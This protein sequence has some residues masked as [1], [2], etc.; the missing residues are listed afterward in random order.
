MH[1]TGVG[2]RCTKKG[3]MRKVTEPLQV[4]RQGWELCLGSGM[5]ASRGRD[6]Y[7]VWMRSRSRF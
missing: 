1:Q 2:D 6:V 3:E 4:R 7:V 5:S